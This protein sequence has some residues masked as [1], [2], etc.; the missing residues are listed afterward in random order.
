MEFRE[1]CIMVHSQQI[2]MRQNH[3][4][5]LHGNMLGLFMCMSSTIRP[6]GYHIFRSPCGQSVDHQWMS[7]DCSEKTEIILEHSQMEIKFN[8]CPQDD[9]DEPP[10]WGLS[11]NN[12]LTIRGQLGQSPDSHYFFVDWNSWEWLFPCS[13]EWSR[14]H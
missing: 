11:L 13:R 3:P 14:D 1:N 8:F 10:A 6:F 4:R 12:P 9:M 7:V 5:E 2:Q